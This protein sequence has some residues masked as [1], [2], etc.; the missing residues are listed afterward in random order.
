MTHAILS[1]CTLQIV[2]VL[3][4]NPKQLGHKIIFNP[5]IDSNPEMRFDS[6]PVSPT[7]SRENLRLTPQ[8]TDGSG[9]KSHLDIRRSSPSGQ[10]ESGSESVRSEGCSSVSISLESGRSSRISAGSI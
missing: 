1:L 6:R 7:V 9:G 3:Y 8:F 2:S 5:L 4:G 10:Y